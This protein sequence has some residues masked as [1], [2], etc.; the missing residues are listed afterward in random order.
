MNN[1]KKALWVSNICTIELQDKK[2]C[3]CSV[4]ENVQN[5][6]ERDCPLLR[7]VLEYLIFVF[8]VAFFLMTFKWKKNV[9]NSKIIVNI[10]IEDVGR[11]WTE[12]D[13]R[14]NNA[15]PLV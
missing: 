9:L 8:Y 4:Q 5:S 12:Q 2:R 11:F 15:R 14:V 10:K 1:K 13:D 7:C 6:R 3:H